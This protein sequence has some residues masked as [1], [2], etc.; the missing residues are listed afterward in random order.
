[1]VDPVTVPC[2]ECTVALE[3]DSLDLRLEL[4]YDDEPLVHCSDCW[5]REFGDDQR[6]PRRREASRRRP[7]LSARQG[8][9]QQIV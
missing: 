4:T 5:E 9:I 7:D 1:M 8:L 6:S 2:T 3:S